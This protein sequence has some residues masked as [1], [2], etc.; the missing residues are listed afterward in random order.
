MKI[1]LAWR[2]QTSLMTMAATHWICTWFNF[3]ILDGAILCRNLLKCP[4][5]A[6]LAVIQNMSLFCLEML[7]L[8]FCHF[9]RICRLSVNQITR[10]SEKTTQGIVVKLVGY[11]HCGTVLTWMVIRCWIIINSCFF[12]WFFSSFWTNSPVDS[13]RELILRYLKLYI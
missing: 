9:C 13:T 2:P 11:I 4:A 8:N 10:S 1:V 3:D 7:K 6:K 5:Q 12:L